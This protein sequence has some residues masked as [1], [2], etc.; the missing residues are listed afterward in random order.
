MN[1]IIIVNKSKNCTSNNV[2]NKVKHLLN[3]KVGH[4]GTLD[5][6]ATGVL[7]LLLGEGTKFSKYLINHDKKY[8]ATLKLGIKM[9]TADVEGDVIEE[10]AVDDAIF[11]SEF[12]QKVLK[13]FEGKQ[14]QTPPVYSAIKI[15][16]KKLYEYA[17]KNIEVE[18]PKREIIIYSINLVE[19]R[20]AENTIVFDVECSKGTYIRSLCEDIA[21][22]LNTVGYMLDLDRQQVGDFSIEQSVTVD[23]IELNRDNNEWLKNHVISLE[24]VLSE[25][26]FVVIPE[27][28]VT[29]LYNGIKIDVDKPDGVYRL[30]VED[31]FIG[32][33]VCENGKLKRDIILG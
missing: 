10:K 27:K 15:N 33:G 20:Q 13:T 1:G 6:N 23:E 31:K 16:G 8:R 5:P 14:I 32:S 22:K 12:L 18:V 7:P 25:S 2:V 3:C 28:N 9:S 24:Q 26:D 17:R 4:T 19:F 29:K 11:K 21:E 30:Y